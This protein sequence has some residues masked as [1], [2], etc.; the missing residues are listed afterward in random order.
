[1]KEIDEKSFDLIKKVASN[2]S[3]P[4]KISQ[5]LD[6]NSDIP[7]VIGI[8]LTN[9]CNLRCKHCY[10]W[11]ESGYH[12]N[13]PKDYKNTDIDLSIITKCI[14]ET[15][16]TRAMFYLWGGEPLLYSNMEDL[17][18][19]LID[20]DRYTVICTNGTL[21]NKFYKKISEFGKNIEL[22]LAIDG[23]EK[24]HD[25]LRGDGNFNL[26]ME[27]IKPIL[28]LK[29]EGKFYGTISV[30][31]M[32]SNENIHNLYETVCFLDE[33]GIDNLILCLPWYISKETS[34][35]MDKYYDAYFSKFNLFNF[36]ENP[37]WHAYKYKIHNSNFD[38]VE[39]TLKKIRKSNFK[40]NVKFQ[41]DIQGNELFSFLSG[42]AID[43]CD[44]R[45]CYTIFSR[46]DVLPNGFVT[47]CKHFQELSYG[48]LNNN[49]L[50]EIWQ[51]RE[52]EYIR[53]TI[54]KHQMPVCSKCN[55]LY[56]H[57]YKKK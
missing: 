56:N 4:K 38:A 33:L 11:N 48:D 5:G 25:A 30:H 13:L 8:K 17:L 15:E 28:D 42:E 40:M 57:S 21:L 32:I 2:I 7:Y 6:E 19:C 35:E 37:S 53:K 51:S 49:S 16:K 47:S 23:D 10:E 46:I 44:N 3:I 43:K 22:L 41:P 50:S 20:N 52:L 14:K 34:Y 31:T 27:R 39:Q 24:S 9:R 29:K 1:M 12:H 54:S 36:D 45:E 55:N 18:Q 26:V